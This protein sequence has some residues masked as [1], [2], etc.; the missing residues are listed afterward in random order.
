MTRVRRYVILGG[1][2]QLGRALA[3]CARHF[4][5]RTCGLYG[6]SEGNFVAKILRLARAGKPLRVVNDQICTPTSAAELAE[7]VAILANGDSFGLY[8]ITNGGAC[9][10]H[11]FAEA[12]IAAAKCAATVEAISSRDYAA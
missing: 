9:S 6:E 12:A 5:I 8:H 4:I 10:W 11:E 7:T 2:G 3:G 1:G